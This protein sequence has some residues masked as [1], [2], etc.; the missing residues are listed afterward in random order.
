M[1][2]PF[3]TILVAVMLPYIWATAGMIFKIKMDGKLD[4]K[5]P[6]E[7]SAR[8][9]GIGKRCNAA[10]SNS[11]EALAVF[12]AC[13]LSAVAANVEPEALV[14]P[15]TVWVGFRIMHGLSYLADIGL[16]RMISFTGGMVCSFIIISKVF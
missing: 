12:S 3:W 1:D 14:I 6:R 11:W 10:Q 4:L 7:Q 16:L 9:E 13:F 2:Y 8:L 5:A 15:A